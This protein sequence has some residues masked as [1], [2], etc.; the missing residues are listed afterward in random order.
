MKTCINRK[1]EIPADPLDQHF[2]KS[3]S[4]AP[5]LKHSQSASTAVVPDDASVMIPAE[6]TTSTSGVADE[7]FTVVKMRQP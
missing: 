3:K 1:K 6:T 2:S 4:S 5:Q 7:M